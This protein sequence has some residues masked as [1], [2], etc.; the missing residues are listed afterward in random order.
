MTDDPVVDRLTR[1]VQTSPPRTV[2]AD[3]GTTP[4]RDRHRIIR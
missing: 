1:S 3:G 4:G 2:R